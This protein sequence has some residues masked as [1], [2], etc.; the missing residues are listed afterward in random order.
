[1]QEQ[2]VTI[3]APQDW[4]LIGTLFEQDK[5]PQRGTVVLISGAAA[6]PHSYYANFARFL[7]ENGAAAV[8]CYDYRGIAASAG[9]KNRW[10]RLK[11]KDW[12]LLDFPA[13]A[14]W[15]AYN[16]PDADLVGLGH[17]YG[18][19]A[20][21]LSGVAQ[22]FERYATVATM[23][24]YWRTLDTPISAWIQTQI[25]GRLVASL[26]GRVPEAVSPGTTM[27]GGVFLD[28]ARWIASPV[29]FFNDPD[30]PETVRF[31]DV[32]LPYL[33]IGLTD[34]PW[35][36]R[37]A[38]DDFMA[39][40]TRAEL[41]QMWIEPAKSG[42]IGHLGFFSRRHKEAFWPLL[43]QFILHGQWPEQAEVKKMVETS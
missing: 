5:A 34:D 18:G 24:G 33:S 41:R 31:S 22:Q 1:M 7:I 19:Q 10:R 8:L 39:N 25:V 40:Y 3:E 20:L 29:Y 38:V 27:P 36:T 32:T 4:L 37:R 42:A 30:L 16:Y 28:W 12:A 15:L 43:A 11:M 13:A 21:G 17:S 23:S 14:K 2:S 26:L 35:G 9:D 6:V